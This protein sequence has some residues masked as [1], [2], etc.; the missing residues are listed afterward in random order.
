MANLLRAVDLL[1]KIAKRP[2]RMDNAP[3]Q[4]SRARQDVREA[5]SLLL[6]AEGWARTYW[7]SQTR[8]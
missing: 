8:S 7:I 2:V 1:D 5:R 4:F 6:G 3:G